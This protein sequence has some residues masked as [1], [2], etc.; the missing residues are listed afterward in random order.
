[1][2]AFFS[3]RVSRLPWLAALLSIASAAWAGT[4]NI[5]NQPLASLP[6]VSASPNLLLLLDSSGS[7]NWSYMPDDLGT[8][9][10]TTDVPN[11]TWY[12]YYSPQCNGVAYDPNNTY[13]PP[14]KADGTSY[15]D[16]SFTAAWKDGYS[17]GSTTDLSTKF[18]AVYNSSGTQPAM[19]WIYTSA[20][21]TKN[22][23]Y[24]E[25]AS[26]VRATTTTTRTCSTNR[27][28]TTTCS[29]S[30][31]TVPD[32]TTALGTTNASCLTGTT[33]C[34]ST[35][36]TDATSPGSSVFTLVQTS[37]LTAAQ[38]T[39][40]ANWYSY[41]SH[42][43]LLMR[44]AMGQAMQTLNPGGASTNPGYRV[45]FSNIYDTA[46]TDGTNNFVSVNDFTAAQMTK[47]YSSLYTVAPNGGTP[48]PDALSQAGR[49]FANKITGQ[50]AD[51]MQYACQRNYTLLT[52]DGYWNSN[53]KAYQLNGTSTVDNQDGSE[54]TPMWDG[55]TTTVTTT[56]VWSAPATR[57]STAAGQTATKTWT[58]NGTKT[59]VSNATVTTYTRSSSK[60]YV[61]TKKV[62]PVLV[63]TTTPTTQTYVETLTQ[64][65]T[66]P[67]T[68]TAKY[69][70]TVIAVNGVQQSDTN[71]ATSY[72]TWQSGPPTS[73]QT[74]DTG[75]P[76]SLPSASTTYATQWVGS[77]TGWTPDGSATN[78]T[79]TSN[80]SN[81]GTAVTTTSSTAPSGTCTY[82]NSPSD[83]SCTV[84][85]STVS[86]KWT[87]AVSGPSQ[88]SWSAGTTTTSD[89]AVG[90]YAAGSPSSAT[91]VTG[92]SSNTLSDVAEYY[93]KTDLRN[94]AQGNCSSTSS[95]GTQDV[96]AD[97]VPTTSDD[98]AKYQHMNTFT[99][100][101][102]VNGTLPK[103]AD[104]LAGLKAGTITWP[105]PAT[106]G[107]ATNIDDLWHAALNGRGQ[108]YSALSAAQLSSAIS[109]VVN[110][111]TA[112]KGAGSGSS[113]SSL[114]LVKGDNNQ[115][116][117]ASYTTSEWTGE[118]LAQTLNG[119]GT[120]KGTVWSAQ[121]LLDSQAASSR[122]IYFNNSGALAAFTY[123]NLSAG[124]KANFDSLCSKTV[125]A[126]QCATLTSANLTIANSGTNL[127]NYLRGDRTNEGTAYRTRK[128]VLGDIINGAPV[129]VGKPPFNYADSGYSD[130]VTNHASRTPVVYTAGNDGMLHAFNATTG[131][132][133]W[134]YVPT[135]VMPNLYQLA[136]NNYSVNHQFFVDGA[137]VEADVM[138][139]GTWKTILV[140]GFNAGG[141]GYYA[142]DIT[143]PS[144]PALLW[145]FTDANLG[146]SYGNPVITKNK[147]GTWVVAFGSGYNNTDGDGNGHLFVVNAQT[148][149][150]ILDIPTNTS[151]T[152]AA[153]ST[154][155]PSGLAK[156]NAWIDT[157]TDNT[158]L[159]FYGGDLLGN[160]WRFDTDNL[161][162]PNQKALLL[163]TLKDKSGNAQPITTRP[164]TVSIKGRPAVAIAT[165]RYLGSTDI[166]DTTQQ[167]LYVIADNLDT[168][169]GWAGWNSPNPRTN[170]TAF[171]EG[172]ATLSGSTYTVT[173]KSS[174]TAIDFTN[175]AFGGWYMDLPHSGER[176]FTDMVLHGL[177]LTMTTA[178]PSGDACKSGGSSWIY[179]INLGTLTGNAT[180]WSLTS[181]VVG[182]S[183]ITNANGDVMDIFNGSDGTVGV[184]TPPIS[185]NT[186]SGVTTRTSWRELSN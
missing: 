159:R 35:T 127:V 121:S 176:V 63:T 138:W 14:V 47:F 41:Y 87:Y 102:G 8:S 88:S 84:A 9:T 142:L 158:S 11:I 183:E 106:S 153:G 34:T 157:S 182:V 131:A 156:I 165:G 74:G 60:P 61:Y 98:P 177:T 111:I 162:S 124:L 172:V 83:P 26:T 81:N 186:L 123:A 10:S 30:T 20:G 40:Y 22:T 115:I 136:N 185:P 12:G 58:V 113:T 39:N 82:T 1:M 48:L 64:S 166:S 2:A 178:V 141:K 148:G 107:N 67:Q 140:G 57:T 55:T 170:T 38:K 77:G 168:V 21:V 91:T 180:L 100:G 137:P 151:G 149:A 133:M 17:Q 25:C 51:P 130:F 37:S 171:V 36:T 126:S 154:T 122:T 75:A 96:C 45:G 93:Y 125:V 85:G 70:E 65:T 33:S 129:Y 105:T 174:T 62:Q 167:T 78:S 44:T 104:T 97:I 42:R 108:Y 32:F 24:N 52:T 101:L 120:I 18:Y 144:S 116:Y 3:P 175:T 169:S 7:M 134:A 73:T 19:G 6:S 90:T 76:S 71:G 179:Y 147:A 99:I 119:D 28:G 94:T 135:A 160:V 117:T 173:P 139:G 4:T 152:T 59:V 112:V 16:A 150:K 66:T 181:L 86:T 68:G 92:G 50:S 184:Q 46:A 95:G 29:N 128:H 161:V 49:Y 80:T 23:F 5:S 27:F 164:E 56:T 69:T 114:A 53:S 13:K 163:A 31:S 132:E 89:P 155:T 145:E 15:S 110:S 54:V 146:L 143:N 103:T 79:S 43:Y 109:S 72:S 118:L